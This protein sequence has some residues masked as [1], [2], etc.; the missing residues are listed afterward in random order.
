MKERNNRINEEEMMDTM[1][2]DTVTVELGDGSSIECVVLMIF[3][4]GEGEYIALVPEE[5]LEQE[6]CEVYL[7]RY[8]EDEDGN[9]GLDNIMSDEEYQVVSDAFSEL[10]EDEA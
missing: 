9:P 7:Y 10:I 8:T 2:R 4:A 1:Q 6:D 5:Q 3:E